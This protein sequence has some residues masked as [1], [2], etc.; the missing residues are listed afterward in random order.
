MATL[1][2]EQLIRGGRA[3]SP[4][5]HVFV[6]LG[7][8]RQRVLRGAGVVAGTLALVWLVALGLTMA[9]STRLTDLPVGVK[10]VATRDAL[11]AATSAPKH[12]Q[13]RVQ[14][15]R[16]TIVTPLLGKPPRG[17]A[18]SSPVGS[19]ASAPAISFPTPAAPSAAPPASVT[20]T[21]PQVTAATPTRGWARR[22]LT[23]PP[24]QT[25][26]N[27]PTPRALDRSTDAK[28]TS[29]THGN[30]HGKG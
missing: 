2:H 18:A 27:E 29:T 4:E 9:G 8:R 17:G 15:P 6:S 7:G 12:S 3:R 14:A 30:G 20:P 24:G 5:A 23:T 19:T 16:V 21:T 22:G 1:E 25:K 11:A 28:T 26:R 13:V 10:R